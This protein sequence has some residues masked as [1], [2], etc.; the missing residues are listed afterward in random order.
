MIN[1]KTAIS[2]STSIILI[3]ISIFTLSFG[4]FGQSTSR[5]RSLDQVGRYSIAVNEESAYLVDTVTGCV[6]RKPPQLPFILISVEGLFEV[7]PNP[8]DEKGAARQIPDRCQ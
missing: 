8:K 6:W 1:R 4:T 2:I 5:S 7:S 3:L